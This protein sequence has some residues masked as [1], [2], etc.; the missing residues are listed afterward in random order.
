M[1]IKGLDKIRERLSRLLKNT[2]RPPEPKE[3]YEIRDTLKE[4]IIESM[5]RGVSPVEGEGR[6]KDYSDSYKDQIGG[7]YKNSKGKKIK[8]SGFSSLKSKF[9]KSVR[10]VNLKL[11]GDMYESLTIKKAQRGLLINFSSPLAYIHDKLGAGKKRVIRR[12]LPRKNENFSGAITTT[13]TKASREYLKRLL[14]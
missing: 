6:Y 11:S 7:V 14:E 3:L 9:N 2:E 10:P 4:Q 12:I 8:K 5:E 13:L 1:A